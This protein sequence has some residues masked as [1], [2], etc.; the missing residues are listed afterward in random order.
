[1]KYRDTYFLSSEEALRVASQQNKQNN[2]YWLQTCY[3]EGEKIE[4]DLVN[5]IHL[6][7]GNLVDDLANGRYRIPEKVEFEGLDISDDIKISIYNTPRRQ[8]NFF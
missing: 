8:D 2:G 5:L 1:M 3:Y 7:L 6:P 4:S